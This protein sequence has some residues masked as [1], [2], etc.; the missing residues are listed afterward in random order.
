[1]VDP[2]PPT[3]TGYVLFTVRR[4]PCASVDLTAHV[5]A[6]R[7]C[8]RRVMARYPFQIDSGVV[9]PD[10]MHMIWG[11]P[12]GADAGLRWRLVKTGLSR[13][14]RR[15]DPARVA[16]RDPSRRDLG[17]WQPGQ[18]ARVIRTRDDLDM[19]RQVV[20]ASPVVAGLVRRTIDW[21]HSSI[22]RHA[23]ARQPRGASSA[24]QTL[25]FDLPEIRPPEAP[26]D[27]ADQM[28]AG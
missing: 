26:A 16:P 7:V 17:I 8:L 27:R 18:G 6:L 4:A 20:W 2:S 3:P 5:H 10:R 13:H 15:A 28:P 11:L 9:L 19:C 25:R 14:L 1:M 21:P 24:P 23:S 22:H 12:P